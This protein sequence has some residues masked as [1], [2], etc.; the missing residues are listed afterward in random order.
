VQTPK[1]ITKTPAPNARHPYMMSAEM[2]WCVRYP[3]PSYCGRL[4]VG[5]QR[6]HVDQLGDVAT[7][8]SPTKRKPKGAVRFPATMN[9]CIHLPNTD[10]Q[11]ANIAA[12]LARRCLRLV[13][14]WRGSARC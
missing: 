14:L 5:T 9:T 1:R 13:R 8:T 10:A 6:W 11:R 12:P 7:P 4:H 2:G 3:L